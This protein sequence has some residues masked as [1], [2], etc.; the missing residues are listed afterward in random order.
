MKK[1]ISLHKHW[2]T[3]DAV[4]QVVFAEI[5]PGKDIDLPEYL[6]ELGKF[7]NK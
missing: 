2:I 4:K 7:H 1:M 3:A 6:I 5:N